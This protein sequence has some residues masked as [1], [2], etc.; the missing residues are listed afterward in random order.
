M[1]RLRASACDSGCTL[2][3]WPTP[4]KYATTTGLPR[5]RAARSYSRDCSTGITPSAVPCIIIGGPPVQPIRHAASGACR[6]GRR[7]LP[8][9]LRHRWMR[10]T[11]L[12]SHRETIRK[13][14]Y[15][16]RARSAKSWPSRSVPYRSGRPERS[17]HVREGR[18]GR[19]HAYWR[20]VSTANTRDEASQ[21]EQQHRN[22]A[23]RFASDCWV[24]G[25][26]DAPSGRARQELCSLIQARNAHSQ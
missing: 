25:M 26:F 1:A 8:P 18:V 17:R 23:A 13:V 12:H 7:Q 22:S 2:T 4:S 16:R 24:G 21:Q 6:P 14:R 11:R 19:R 3:T 5:A 9:G 15:G 10:P 20:G